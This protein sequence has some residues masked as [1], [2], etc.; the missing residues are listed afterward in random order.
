MKFFLTAALLLAETELPAASPLTV[1]WAG[2]GILVASLMIAWG[3]EATQFFLAQG[4]ALA[5]LALLQTLPEFAMEA[6]FA[7]HQQV[8]F[9]FASLTGALMLLTGL[10]W[11]MIYFSAARAYRREFKR[12]PLLRINLAAEHSVQ[13]LALFVAIAYEA[14]VWLKGALTIYDGVA[15][16]AIYAGYVW[17]MRRLPPEK[18]EGIAE[19]AVIPRSII[20]ARKP[21]RIAAILGLFIVGGAIV[22]LVANPFLEGLFGLSLLIGIPKFQFVQWIAPLVSEAPEG[23]SAYYWA[24]DPYRA[25]IALMNLVSSNINQWTLL[26]GLLPLVLSL[27]AGHIASIPLDAEQSRDLLLTLSQSLLGA[28]FLLKL[29]LAWWEATGL[30]VLFL[31][32]LAASELH[33]AV[34]WIDFGWCGV[35]LLRFLTGN[36]KAAALSHFR[37]V[38]R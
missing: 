14:I 6:V 1:L 15:L 4:I 23:I 10:G 33:A 22:F 17:I 37:G 26:A 9:L 36:R 38:T 30:F 8:P 11:P 2:P 3:A 25:P 13:V 18:H 31:V 20:L 12:R 19:I 16:I 5:V 29:E 7:W 34:T 27:S 28:L 21:V 24:R 32:Q 35:E